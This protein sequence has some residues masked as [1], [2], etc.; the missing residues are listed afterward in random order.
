M[1][2]F[3]YNIILFLIGNVDLPVRVDQAVVGVYR[4]PGVVAVFPPAVSDQS[5]ALHG[6]AGDLWWVHV[7]EEHQL[8]IFYVIY[9]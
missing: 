3:L 5:H 4:E 2:E 6:I 7:S 1:R 9:I 8:G